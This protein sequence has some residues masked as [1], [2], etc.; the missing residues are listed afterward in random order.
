MAINFAISKKCIY[1][2]RAL[3][4]LACRDT[5]APVKIRQIA[6]SQGIPSRFLEVILSE[7]RRASFLDSRRGAEGG[8]VLASEPHTITVG[9]VL[10]YVQGS[11]PDP[12]PTFGGPSG[13]PGDFAFARFWQ[14]LNAA[15]ADVADTTTL[16]DLVEY[17][18]AA[19]RKYIPNY[20]I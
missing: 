18:R 17:D 13:H 10:R 11:K 16:A 7:L 3:F 4:E 20:V 5:D 19:D 15:V 6:D 12:D 8:Y 14:E 1:A 2:L 9:D